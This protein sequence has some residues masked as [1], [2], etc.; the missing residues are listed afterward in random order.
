MGSPAHA[1]VSRNA[2]QGGGRHLALAAAGEGLPAGKPSGVN[3]RQRNRVIYPCCGFAGGSV[4]KNPPVNAGDKRGRFSPWVGKIPGR[5]A[6][7]PTPVFL[8]G[9]ALGRRSLAG[10][11]RVVGSALRRASVRH[12]GSDGEYTR[13]EETQQ[14]VI[15]MPGSHTLKSQE[16][17]PESPDQKDQNRTR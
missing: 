6:W 13:Y 10:Y 4:V 14:Q 11:R 8:P 1:R 17:H 9:E 2:G 15:H 16:T 12:S 7:Q 5:R 3:G